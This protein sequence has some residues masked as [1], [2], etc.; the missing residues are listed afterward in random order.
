MV[1]SAATAARLEPCGQRALDSI[2]AV[3]LGAFA[4]HI[5]R[6]ATFGGSSG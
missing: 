6:D 5:L 1:R 2:E 3:R 4:G